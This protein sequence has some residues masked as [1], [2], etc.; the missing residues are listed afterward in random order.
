MRNL[1]IALLTLMVLSGC[2][3]YD[4]G[5]SDG[6]ASGYNTTCNI[7]AT[8]VEDSWNPLYKKGYKEGYA[9]GSLACRRGK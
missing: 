4:S 3:S 1:A 7:R 8:P 9:D 5:Y 6:Y 2:S